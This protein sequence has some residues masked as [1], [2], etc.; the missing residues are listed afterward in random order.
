MFLNVVFVT[1]LGMYLIERLGRRVLT[2]VSLGGIVFSLVL[3]GVGF[4]LSK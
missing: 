1:Y 2:L 3:L 4:Q